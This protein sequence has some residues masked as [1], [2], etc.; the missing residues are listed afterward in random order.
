MYSRIKIVSEKSSRPSNPHL[1]PNQCLRLK[2]SFAHPCISDF[3][4]PALCAKSP[5]RKKM[6]TSAYFVQACFE[7][8]ILCTS[9]FSP[10]KVEQTLIC[11]P[12]LLLMLHCSFSAIKKMSCRWSIAPS[13]HQSFDEELIG[14]PHRF[15][16][17]A[18][19]CVTPLWHFET[20]S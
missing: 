11:P 12:R 14:A 15:F 19:R 3:D 13:A 17:E 9:F 18:D 8:S 7:A 10:T 16:D 4:A 6:R 2:P 1:F 5:A 20:R